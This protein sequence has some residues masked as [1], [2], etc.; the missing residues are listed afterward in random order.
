MRTNRQL[1][2]EWMKKIR[3]ADSYV[4]E[5]LI[6][7]TEESQTTLN[8]YLDIDGENVDDECLMC[9]DEFL[10]EPTPEM[11]KKF[12]SA[13]RYFKEYFENVNVIDKIVIV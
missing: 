3:F 5:I 12:K 10:P 4:I 2:T 7:C 8:I 11:R 6:L 13:A 1:K 9:I